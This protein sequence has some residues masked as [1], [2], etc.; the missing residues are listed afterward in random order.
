MSQVRPGDLDIN[1]G[2]K[3]DGIARIPPQNQLNPDARSFQI[4]PSAGGSDGSVAIYG[5]NPDDPDREYNFFG[6]INADGTW[7]AETG[8]VPL[9]KNQQNPMPDGFEQ[10]STLVQ[11]SSNPDDGYLTAGFVYKFDGELY[12]G[13]VAVGRY[14]RNFSPWENFGDDGIAHTLKMSASSPSVPAPAAPK[15]TSDP[16]GAL[17]PKAIY[18]IATPQVAL[19]NNL[20][21]VVYTFYNPVDDTSEVWCALFK[22][23]TGEP[24][25]GLGQEQ[26]KSQLKLPEIQGDTLRVMRCTFLSDGSFYL[27]ATTGQRIHLLRFQSNAEL[28]LTFA[29]GTGYITRPSGSGAGLAVSEDSVVFTTSANWNAALPDDTELYGF[30]HEGLPIDKFTRSFS[31]DNGNLALPWIA[32]DSEDR[33]IL[34]GH[35]FYFPD[36][37]NMVH[38]QIHVAR[39]TPDGDLD[40]NF[41]EGGFTAPHPYLWETTGLFVNGRD[42]RVLTSMPPVGQIYEMLA[43]YVA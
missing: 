6:R 31:M 35:R 32:F 22:P 10:F 8:Y 34:A 16:A 25:F 27:L 23:E 12:E 18:Y 21:R 30:N 1:Y 7:D 28:D 3:G 20:I 4:L 9:S 40:S 42:I 39:L 36:H 29:N 5:N 43:R 13:G 38:A 33:L 2:T 41:G 19:V 24:A 26:D 11:T 15:P 37:E 14:D 17:S